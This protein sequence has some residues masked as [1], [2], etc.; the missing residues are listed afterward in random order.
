M[1]RTS[2]HT[3]HPKLRELEYQ[4]QRIYLGC[5]ISH[6]QQEPDIQCITFHPKLCELEYQLQ[7]I[8]LACII[9]HLQQEPDIQC[10]TFHPKLCELEYQLQR[11]YLGWLIRAGYCF[12]KTHYNLLTVF[13]RSCVAIA[14]I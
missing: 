14:L 10:I 3:F 12:W 11:I 5:I 6:P 8:Y 2:L 9:S 4:L 13:A 1:S 7:R